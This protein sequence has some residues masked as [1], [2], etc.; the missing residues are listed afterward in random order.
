MKINFL[1]PLC[2]K[3]V[4]S[5]LG[6]VTCLRPLNITCTCTSVTYQSV[7]RVRITSISDKD[8]HLN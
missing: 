5:I 3:L 1:N 2:I 7:C 4:H 8:E 6:H